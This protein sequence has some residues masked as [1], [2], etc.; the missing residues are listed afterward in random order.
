MFQPALVAP[1][2]RGKGYRL[3]TAPPA[4]DT[5]MALLH[6]SSASRNAPYPRRI[7][8][9]AFKTRVAKAS[10][11]VESPDANPSFGSL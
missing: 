9:G 7:S 8:G 11:P 4:L 2:C 5:A 6:G 10:H 3:I 1:F